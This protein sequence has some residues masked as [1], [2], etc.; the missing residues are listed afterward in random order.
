M[1]LATVNDGTSTRVVID[2][3]RGLV[4]VSSATR[5][6]DDHRWASASLRELLTG[7]AK[8]R[9]FLDRAERDQDARCVAESDVEFLPPVPD[10]PR[11]F[12]VGR[13]YAEHAREGRAEVP[14]YPMIFLKPA[15]SLLGHDQEVLVP[16]STTKVDWEGEIAVVIGRPGRDIPED[17]AWE[18]V[19]GFTPANDLS[20]RDW[21]RRT[22]QF[23]A[24]KM[25][26]GFG[27]M[28]P[29][30]VTT[31]EIADID[32]VE[33]TTRVNGTTMQSG[34]VRDMVFPIPRLVSYLSEAVRLLPGDV[35]LTGTPSGVGYARTPPIFLEAGDVV[36]VSVD[37]VG[38]LRNRIGSR[39]RADAVP[40]NGLTASV[41][42]SA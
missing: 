37:Q 25:F 41:H 11:I 42:P 1:R 19:A 28:G 21:Q 8:A 29:F 35:I 34:V 33:L 24:G 17:R 4:D 5:S 14:D 12:C 27:P 18:H 32:S 7:G 39:P 26:D 23:D 13:N 15:T 22:S 2:S 30:L 36:E 38:L 31:D 20:A 16:P 6:D 40:Q 3:P 10:P 9:A